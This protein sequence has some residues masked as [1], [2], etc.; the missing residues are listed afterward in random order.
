M[1]FPDDFTGANGDAWSATYWDAASSGTATIE[2]NRGRL[3]IAST[4][5]YGTISAKASGAVEAADFDYTLELRP[6]AWGT[7]ENRLDIGFRVDATDPYLF[8]VSIDV[9]TLWGAITAGRVRLLRND[10]GAI[11]VHG[12]KQITVATQPTSIFVHLVASGSN[13]SMSAWRDGE[14]EPGSF[15]VA[16]SD[17]TYNSNV[18]F[19][20][21]TWGGEDPN[22]YWDID[23]YTAVAALRRPAAA[24]VWRK[25]LGLT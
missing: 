17:G 21:S 15:D 2:S 1:A 9:S 16:V 11:T 3:F 7:Q 18:G 20:F 14:S 23:P 10:W 22:T 8:Q 4:W 12:T 5:S 6:S 13:I 25:T 24:P 19:E